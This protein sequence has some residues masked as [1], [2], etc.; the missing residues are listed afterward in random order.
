[1]E[2][3]IS[4][5]KVGK[6]LLIVIVV[7]TILSLAGQFYKYLLFGGKDRYIINLFSL[8]NEFNIPTWYQTITLLLCSLLTGALYILSKSRNEFFKYHWLGLSIIF[9][10]IASDEILVLHEQII[11][12]LRGLLGTS[13]FFY[14]A[15]IIPAIIFGI[16]F[17]VAYF[18]FLT[19]LPGEF[20]NRFIIAGVLYILGA[21]GL[22]AVSG[23][24]FTDY[25]SNTLLYSLLTNVEEILEMVGILLFIYAL[26]LY[27]KLNYSS[28]NISIINKESE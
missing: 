3:N 8:N 19:S 26:L 27:Y 17:L 15:W 13:G 7:V 9:F 2:L 1:M 21:V 4:P 10:Y 20:R 23:K 28:F 22:E 14:Y 18:K 5:K 16:I 6:M 11:S 12:P 24:V 25:G